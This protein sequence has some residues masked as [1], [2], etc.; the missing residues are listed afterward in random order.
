M[1]KRLNV[2]GIFVIVMVLLMGTVGCNG[3]YVF[4]VCA[5]EDY[6]GDEQNYVP[7]DDLLAETMELVGQ[8]REV[9]N[10]VEDG[11]RRSLIDNRDSGVILDVECYYTEN[12][13]QI[14]L[15]VDD[16]VYDTALSAM[17]GGVESLRTWGELSEFSTTLASTYEDIL[18]VAVFV[19]IFTECGI[20]L[21]SEGVR[22][23]I[24][25]V[26]TDGIHP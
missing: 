2:L 4:E 19:D 11:L 25:N 10:T 16:I 18:G 6:A 3:N 14:N 26:V 22:I 5:G 13:F 15:I 7:D 8:L 24:F 21:L 9:E 20:I 12:Y 1:M 17:R 23:T